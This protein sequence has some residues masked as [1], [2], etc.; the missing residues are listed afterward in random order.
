MDGRLWRED[1][2][3]QE[4]TLGKGVEKV[5]FLKAPRGAGKKDGEGGAT[6][7]RKVKAEPTT[8]SRKSGRTPKKR[9]ESPPPPPG[10]LRG[11]HGIRAAAS[12]RRLQEALDSAP[13]QKRSSLSDSRTKD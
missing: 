1:D 13:K 12:A 2:D 7:R 8:P 5:G 3:E 9:A 4:I 6:P 11:S 10:G